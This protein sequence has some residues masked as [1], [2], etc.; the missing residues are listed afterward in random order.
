MS[1]INTKALAAVVLCAALGLTGCVTTGS[2]TT[3]GPAR[4]QDTI[5]ADNAIADTIRMRLNEEPRFANSHVNVDVF[6]GYIVLSGQVP[7]KGMVSRAEDIAR[8]AGGVRGLYNGLA[9]GDNTSTWRHISDGIITARINHDIDNAQL[10]SLSRVHVITENGIVFLMGAIQRYEADGIA[11][12][13]A[14]VDGV[15]GVVKVF[16]YVD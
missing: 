4:S 6:N 12:I 3:L 14:Q 7:I 9:V 5:N 1:I 15:N 2:P 16:E 13:A 8:S 10:S 11:R